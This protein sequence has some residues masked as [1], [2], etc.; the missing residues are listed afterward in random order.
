MDDFKQEQKDFLTGF[1]TRE[2]LKSALTKKISDAKLNN[3]KFFLL[4]IDIDHFKKINDKYGHLWGDEFLKFVGSTLRLS[5]EDKGLIFRY[6][7]DEFVVLFATQDPKQAFAL[8]K[9]FNL[10]M[11][12]RPFLF[13]G[14]LF[15]ITISCGLVTFPSDANNAEDLIKVA[16]KALYFSKKY[17]RNTTTWASKIGLQQLK[18][19]SAVFVEVFLLAAIVFSVHNYF[20]QGSFKKLWQRMLTIRLLASPKQAESI[21]VLKTGEIISGSIITEDE[22]KFVVKVALGQGAATM[23]VEKA[24]VQTVILNELKHR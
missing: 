18:I 8:A 7:G 9:Q 17:G 1:Y 10:V 4:L 3:E 14:H 12:S 23:N 19:I 5:L 20:F 2:H 13:N 16:D 11:R 6:G 22:D 15:K 24:L 21:I